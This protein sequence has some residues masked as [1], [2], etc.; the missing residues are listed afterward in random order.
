[1]FC[2]VSCNACHL[3]DPK[4]RCDRARLNI[5]DEP[6]YAPGD[7]SDMFESI[8]ERFGDRYGVEIL[9]RDPWVVTFENFVSDEEID[10]LIETN[11]MFER[12]TDTG[13]TNEFGETGRILSQSRTSQ[14]SWCRKECEEHPD[15]QTLTEKIE[16]VTNVPSSHYESFQVLRYDV[17]QFYRA[18]HDYGG[19]DR[20]LACGPRIL[21]F[22]LYLSD[23]DGGGE[24]SFP[25]LNIDVKP[26]KGKA[27]LWPSTVSHSPSS[28]DSRTLHEAKIVTAGVKYAANSWIHLYDFEIPNLHGCTGTFDEI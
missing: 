25:K 16:E 4:I 17:G 11:Q 15:V 5:S 10:A 23:V 2:S 6:I 28:V 12:S 14:N 1:M 26:K 7:M 13:T 8:V 18:H 21:T 3:R 22:F 20:G 9:S 24:T 27:L 19:E